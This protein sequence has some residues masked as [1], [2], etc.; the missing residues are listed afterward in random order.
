MNEPSK[1]YSPKCPPFPGITIRKEAKI[2]IHTK[3]VRDYV[4]ED[5]QFV[6][7]DYDPAESVLTIKPTDKNNPHALEIKKGR[8]KMPVIKCKDFLDQS[9]IPYQDGPGKIFKADWDDDS[10][11]ILVKVSY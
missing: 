4:L 8:D 10:K 3:T 5:L 1:G 7:L 6:T 11:A 9:G 2:A